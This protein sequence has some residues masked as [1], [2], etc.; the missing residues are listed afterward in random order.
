MQIHVVPVPWMS[1]RDRLREVRE[2]VFIDE[3]HVPRELE[4]DGADDTAVHFIA[5][6]EAGQ[7]LGCA[8]LLPSGQIGRMAVLREHRG[9]GLGR[10]L[11]DIAIAEAARLG[12]QRV[13]LHAQEHAAEFYRK[14]GFVAHGAPFVE[15]GIPHV[16]M[17]LVLPIPFEPTSGVPRPRVRQEPVRDSGRESRLIT[18]R[19]ER[20]CID[21]LQ[22]V[23]MAAERQLSIL[24][25]EL[26]PLLFDR[27]ELVD[28]LSGFV[29]RASA[30][31]LRILLVDHSRVVSRG[32]R[33]L[34]LA[35]RLD[36][37]IEMRRPPGELTPRDV[38]FAVWDGQGYWLMP[39]SH[40][41][42][43]LRNDYDPVQA[44]RLAGQFQELWDRS[45]PDPELRTL[46]L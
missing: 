15:A 3:Q 29:R 18:D 36:S 16:A 2:R 40:V 5:L 6:N 23:A 4:W 12:M 19:G 38:S 46:R 41:Y 14:V 34:E 7:A 1:H 37:R 21:G 9:T 24:S 39:D 22:H 25:Q 33:L 27:P 45:S 26:D 44:Q 32:H 43:A 10:R 30:V 42:Q 8:R 28:R 31:Q 17:E 35:R 20:E 13:H 11:L